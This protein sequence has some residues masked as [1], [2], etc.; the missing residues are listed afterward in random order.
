[1]KLLCIILVLI[2]VFYLEQRLTILDGELRHHCA[3]PENIAVPHY[4][5]L[6]DLGEDP[7]IF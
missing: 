7:S 5:V 3:C 1:M 2:L 4:V 6:V